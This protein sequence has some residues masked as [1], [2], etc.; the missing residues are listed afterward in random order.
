MQHIPLSTVAAFARGIVNSVET[1]NGLRF[2]RFDAET[3]AYYEKLGAGRYDRACCS[4]GVTLAFRTD[5]RQL[6]LTLDLT[7]QVRAYSFADVC[8]DGLFVASAG[9]ADGPARIELQAALP[10]ERGAMRSVAVHL[11]HCRQAIVRT[12]AVDDGARC[13]ADE[14]RPLLLALGDSITQGM[15]AHH[16]AL[17]YATVMA[18]TLGM[19]LLN[20]GVGGH[21]FDVDGLC[22]PPDPVPDLVTV[23]YG[24]NDW[25]R[26][27]DIAAAR[28]WLARVRAWH[29]ETPVFV[30]EPIWA[31]REGMDVNPG[32]NAAGR[33]LAECR[34]ELGAI[35]NE[36]PGIIRIGSD[37]FLPAVAAFLSDGVH[38]NDAGHVVYGLNAA[39]MI[40]EI[41]RRSA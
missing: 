35:V 6:A 37:R 30:F 38:P 7:T 39:N 15:N 29:P 11:P 8:V 23:A 34:G 4:A 20:Q 25:N 22:A 41:L 33:T 18:R 12:M 14:A 2:E 28:P 13:E 26:G 36:H 5:S 32:P 10:G 27:C 24:I 40:R 9:A 21:V 3:L 1:E 19:T 17:A 16:P 31:G